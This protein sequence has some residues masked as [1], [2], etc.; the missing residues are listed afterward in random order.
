[1]QSIRAACQCI[2]QDTGPSKLARGIAADVCSRSRF[3]V[4][5]VVEIVEALICFNL[6][7]Y[8]GQHELHSRGEKSNMVQNH[9]LYSVCTDTHSVHVCLTMQYKL[10]LHL[11]LD[12]AQELQKGALRSFL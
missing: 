12:L 10:I 7:L 8:L 3:A 6:K 9:T 5:D 1:M 4:V 2:H 11:R